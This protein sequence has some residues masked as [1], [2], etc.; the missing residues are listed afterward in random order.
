MYVNYIVRHGTKVADS[1]STMIYVRKIF[2]EAIK[3]V[4]N[5]G[6]EHKFAKIRRLAVYFYYVVLN[7]L[8]MFKD[9]VWKDQLEKCASVVDE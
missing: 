8:C 2:F 9:E 5:S 7:F 1:F 4:I 3:L 6:T